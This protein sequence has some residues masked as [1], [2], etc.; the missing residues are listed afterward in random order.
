MTMEHARGHPLAEQ[1]FGGSPERRL[2]LL[3]AAWPRAVGAELA[4]RTEVVALEGHAL[5]I[6]VADAGWRKGLWRMRREIL[7]RL[8]R[9]AGRLAPGALTFVE[10]DLTPRAEPGPAAVPAAPPSAPEGVRSQAEHIEDPELRAR[11][12][13]SASRY[14]G[15]FGRSV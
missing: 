5:R 15:R 2:A 13:E 1:L 4:L 14:L 9:V 6:R 12:L 11:F 10:G 7:S 3:R 8:Y